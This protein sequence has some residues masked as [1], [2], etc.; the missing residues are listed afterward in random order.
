M[1]P[2]EML[3]SIEKLQEENLALKR[4]LCA[5]QQFVSLGELVG[6]TTHEF[7]NALMTIINYARMGLRHTD[8][9]TRTKAL[10]KIL[11]ASG[12]ANKITNSV[13]GMARNRGNRFE[14]TCL[15]TIIEETM[16]L[17]EREMQKYR[18]SVDYELASVPQ[19]RAIGNQIHQVLTNLLI[20]ARQAMRDGGRI[21]IKLSYDAE[22]N[23][24]DL[25]VRDFGTGIPAE[26][27]PKVFESGFTT[28]SGRDA[29]GKGGAGLGLF[30]VR[31]IIDEHG[32][33]IRV[34]STPGVG[35]AFT[36]R[37]PAINKTVA[38]PIPLTTSNENVHHPT[39]SPVIDNWNP[40]F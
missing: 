29:S 20:N 30:A 14:T 40:A 31:N 25:C 6:T 3:A 13:L 32:G 10:E 17:L 24:V 19:V 35:T 33:K 11:C 5:M 8:E 34:E 9:A 4:A 27:L 26:Q 36:I 28:K 12:R 22:A 21:I 23:L 18:I 1:R 37:L 39:L 15:A 2:D 38:G 16:V 7:N